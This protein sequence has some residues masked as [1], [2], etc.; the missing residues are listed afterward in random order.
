MEGSYPGFKLIGGIAFLAGG[1]ALTSYLYSLNYITP[2]Y[3]QYFYA[4]FV[5]VGGYI[6]VSAFSTIAYNRISKA[7]SKQTATTVRTF[8]KVIGYVILLSSLTSVLSLNPSFALI[9]GSFTGIV[10]GLA[11]QTVFGNA[12]A[13]V[14]LMVIRPFKVDDEVTVAGNTGKVKSIEIMHTIIET[15]TNEILIPSLT[16]L[17][18]VIIRRRATVAQ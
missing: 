9:V 18:S 16:V 7:A 8:I 13:G 15:Q 6:I 5:V 2:E 17:N 3:I 11:S 4:A 1:A 14:L 12:L 10:A